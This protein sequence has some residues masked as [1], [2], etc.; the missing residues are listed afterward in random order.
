MKKI[1]VN[2]KDQNPN[3]SILKTNDFDIFQNVIF[4]KKIL[5]IIDAAITY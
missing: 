2:L 3:V 1:L 4:R 5:R